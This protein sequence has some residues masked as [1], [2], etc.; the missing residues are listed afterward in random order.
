M[1]RIYRVLVVGILAAAI[2]TPA[3]AASLIESVLSAVESACDGC[4]TSLSIGSPTD[5]TTWR[6]QFSPGATV[7]QQQQ[8]QAALT[9]FP[10]ATWNA[11]QAAQQQAQA[12]LAAGLQITSTSTPALN[13]T[14]AAT[15]AAQGN[16]NAVVT[17]IQ[18]HQSFPPSGGSTM[19][20]YD[21][22]GTPH[23]F[24]STAEFLAFATAEA[25][26]AAS[27]ALG[28]TFSQ[29]ATIP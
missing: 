28:Q 26:F 9:G 5:Q 10:V 23:T 6:V 22:G 21:Q 29:P 18:I 14:Y 25:D 27:V 4:V 24:P 13:G 2:S 16:I 8:A 17:Y 12:T 19:V 3:R 15:P 11:Q 7:S 20:W 1:S